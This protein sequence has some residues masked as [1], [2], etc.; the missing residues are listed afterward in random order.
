VGRARKLKIL[1]RLAEAKTIGLPLV[2]YLEKKF[3]RK[4][5]RIDPET[6]RPKTDDEGRR[7]FDIVYH[8]TRMV[9]GRSTRGLY[10]ALKKSGADRK[11]RINRQEVSGL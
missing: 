2:A 5:L 7:L 11:I 6:R 9:D 4:I 3:P 10:R 8:I 1:R